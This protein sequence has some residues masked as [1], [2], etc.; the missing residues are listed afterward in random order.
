MRE[1]LN[2]PAKFKTW[3][4]CCTCST[5]WVL[6]LSVGGFYYKV[7]KKRRE[8]K[9]FFYACLITKGIILSSIT[10]ISLFLNTRECDNNDLFRANTLS[11]D[12][13]TM[14]ESLGGK[15]WSL[16]SFKMKIERRA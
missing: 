3:I 1:K 13:P 8:L 6:N 2:L 4:R 16:L 9:Y 5:T 10:R 14:V 12:D 11:I 7:K 15:L